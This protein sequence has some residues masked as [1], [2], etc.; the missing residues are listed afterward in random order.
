LKLGFVAPT[1]LFLVTFNLF[2]LF[3]N[4]VLSFTNKQLSQDEYEFVGGHN[5]QTI[6][7]AASN[8]KFGDALRTTG[9]FVLA[10]VTLE[11]VLGFCLALA[12]QAKFRERLSASLA[13]KMR[14]RKRSSGRAFPSSLP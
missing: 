1:L 12:M 11:L 8:P 6:F 10:A 7:D 5:Y 3:Y 13:D 4:I 14:R 2:P 9:S